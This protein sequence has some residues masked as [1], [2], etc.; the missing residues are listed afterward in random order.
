MPISLQDRL[1]RFARPIHLAR[2]SS[3][4]TH[5][6]LTNFPGHA[7]IVSGVMD[8]D[9]PLS[10]ARFFSFDYPDSQDSALREINN[11]GRNHRPGLH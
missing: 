11:A 1:H 3:R 5:A 8:R 6:N 10:P 4:G 2:G 9:E 7:F